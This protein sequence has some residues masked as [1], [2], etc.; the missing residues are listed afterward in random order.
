MASTATPMQG[1][2]CAVVWVFARVDGLEAGRVCAVVVEAE[3]GVEV[4]E[5]TRARGLDQRLG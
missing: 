2:L 3:A 1:Q 5:V 4:R